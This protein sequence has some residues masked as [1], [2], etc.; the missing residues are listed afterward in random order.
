MA[1]SKSKVKEHRPKVAMVTGASGFIGSHV[2]RV[3]LDE[4]VKVRALVRKGDPLN[5][6][7]GLDVE[8]VEGDLL[9]VESL[10]SCL[11]G[12][13]TVFHLA[14]IY[15]YWLPDPSVMYRVNIMGT[16]N[17]LEASLDAGIKKVVYTSSIAAIGTV[18]GQ[19]MAN[20]DTIFNNWLLADHYVM[21]KYMAELE[22][23]S[24][25]TKGL[26]VVAALPTFPFGSLDIAPTPTGV[27]IQRYMDGHNPVWLPGGFNGANVKDVA[28][29]HWLAC[30]RGRPGE[31]YIFGGHN[32][33]YK[34]FGMMVCDIAGVK[35]PTKEAST[36]MLS[37]IGRMCEWVADN[38]THKEPL[39][40]DKAIQYTSGRYLWFDLSKAKNELGYEPTPIDDALRES[41]AWFSEGRDDSLSKEDSV[42]MKSAAV[43]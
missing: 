3:L 28:R 21:S 27:L 6:L 13:D 42:G 43:G 17:L 36:K 2:V 5:N 24:F 31:R 7:Y 9:D 10:K 18:E 39:V 22:A 11:E 15:A 40:V 4:G 30:L 37:V 14:A 33:T 25:N 38:I 41:V 16:R 29:G 12:C 8:R 1:V 23:L 32:L 26:D 19:E 35:R 20:E 34:D